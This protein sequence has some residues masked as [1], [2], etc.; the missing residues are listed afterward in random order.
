MVREQMELEG[1]LP[2]GANAKETHDFVCAATVLAKQMMET[3]REAAT[4]DRMVL[5]NDL[6][7]TFADLADGSEAKTIIKGSNF[8]T[9]SKKIPEIHA[10]NKF[11]LPRK[12][13]PLAAFVDVSNKKAIV[14]DNTTGPDENSFSQAYKAALKGL[15]KELKVKGKNLFHPVRIAL[16]GE[17]NGKDVTKQLSLLAMES[18]EGVAVAAHYVVVFEARM[19][20]LVA[21]CDSIPEE[22]RGV[23]EEKKN[24]KN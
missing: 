21:F 6:P 1:L 12:D 24:D 19:K 15:T 16:T 17:M 5:G 22:F 3:T 14:E 23:E 20:R 9:V 18:G 11:P 10:A 7:A 2:A 8:Y 13:E 4:N